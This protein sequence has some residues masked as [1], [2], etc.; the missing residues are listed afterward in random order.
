MGFTVHVWA[1][2]DVRYIHVHERKSPSWYRASGA[3]RFIIVLQQDRR[4]RSPTPHHIIAYCLEH[5]PANSLR[6]CHPD[7]V[8]SRAAVY[9][10]NIRISWHSADCRNTDRRWRRVMHLKTSVSQTPTRRA[11]NTT[12]SYNLPYTNENH[13]P[14]TGR[15]EPRGPSSSS[16]EPSSVPS[17]VTAQVCRSYRDRETHSRICG[18]QLID[19]VLLFSYGTDGFHL[20]IPKDGKA[21]SVTEMECYC[22]R[23]MQRDGKP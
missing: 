2:G 11:A 22:W 16:L 1:S 21:K 8:S 7:W 13:H 6:R 19:Y 23:L 10:R 18:T 9:R 4:S 17:T 12:P 20:D 3:A 14:D 15:V 5:V